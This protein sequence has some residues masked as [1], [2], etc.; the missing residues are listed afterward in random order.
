[1]CFEISHAFE[2]SSKCIITSKQYRGEEETFP[3]SPPD[4][5]WCSAVST[6]SITVT[7]TAMGPI[8]ATSLC[9]PPH[10]VSISSASIV[11][12]FSAISTRQTNKHTIW[13]IPNICKMRKSVIDGKKMSRREEKQEEKTVQIDNGSGSYSKCEYECVC[14]CLHMQQQQQWRKKNKVQ[15]EM[16]TCYLKPRD[17][18]KLAH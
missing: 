9:V 3:N 15:R 13:S 12:S 8:I 4:K 17:E 1:M 6:L 18:H 7:I 11:S 5:V 10:S 2:I 14:V 16:H